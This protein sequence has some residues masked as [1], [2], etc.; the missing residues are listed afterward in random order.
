MEIYKTYHFRLYPTKE[1]I[2]QLNKTL[3]SVRFVYNYYL[4]KCY[5]AQSCK[6]DYHKFL[7]D[8]PQLKKITEFQ[9][10]N[11]VES[12]TLTYALRNLINALDRYYRGQNEFPVFKKRN[13]ISQTFVTKN[14]NSMTIADQTFLKLPKMT[15]IAYVKSREIEGQVFRTTICKSKT[16]KFYV[17]LTA[18]T[19]ETP[20]L[21]TGQSVGIDLG[22]KN[23]ATLSNGQIISNP[24]FSDKMLKKIKRE[25]RSMY[26]KAKLAKE[27]GID[28]RYA[29]NYQK[30]KMKVARLH[31]KIVNQREDFLDKVSTELI[32]QY[33]VI[34]V[35][36]LAVKQMMKNHDLAYKIAE[37]SWRH[38]ISKL[39]YK[40]KWYG[41]TLIKINRWYP[42]SQICHYCGNIDGKK[43][44]HIR[45]WTCKNCGA[46]LDR[47]VNAAINILNA[48]L[49][50]LNENENRR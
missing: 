7:S 40:S 31:E 13:D 21:K 38:F 48:G 39:E 8:L 41:K 30:Q 37:T 46:E 2:S 4:E 28:L 9:W 25:T 27:K 26:R 49:S 22:I 24:H 45:T 36:N 14:F 5:K 29:K 18:K 43:K 33:D 34:C 16:N 20:L 50:S 47:D 44:L 12:A 35:E 42:S 1:Q 19:Y 15:P 6:S 23:F 10:L 17:S 11:D 32:R 3:G